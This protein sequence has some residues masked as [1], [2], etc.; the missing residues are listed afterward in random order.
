MILSCIHLPAL[1]L[2]NN[3]IVNSYPDA[4]NGMPAVNNA[5]LKE[6]VSIPENEQQ[7][8]HK[9]RIDLEL[10]HARFIRPSRALS[11]ASSAEVRNDLSIRMS[12]FSDCISCRISPIKA[13]VRIKYPSTPVTKPGQVIYVDILPAVSVDSLSPKSYFQLFNYGVCLFQVYQ[14]NWYAL[15]KC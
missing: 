2:T 15:Q 6:S 1:V 11:A 7:K 4:K 13:T 8:C 5:T 9:K 14:G 10:A 3:A 12:L